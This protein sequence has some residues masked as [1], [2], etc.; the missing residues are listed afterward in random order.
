[1]NGSRK[2]GPSGGFASLLGAAAVV[3]LAAG[4]PRV[5]AAQEDFRNADLDRPLLTEDAVPVKLREWEVELGARGRLA[6]GGGTGA[7]AVAE[8]KTGLFLNTQVGVELEGAVDDGAE[9]TESGLESL[10]AHILYGFDRETWSWPAFALRGDVRSPGAGE[11][12]REDWG[13]RV[14]GIA[15]R[16]VGRLRLHA[17]AGYDVA[18]AADGDDAWIAGLAFDYP[19]GLFS[20]LVMADVFVEVPVD[21][22]RTRVW[23][24][25]G[26]RWQLSNLSVL[27]LGLATRLDEWEA[28]RANVE[29][30]VGLSRAF[31]I[32]AL[33]DVPPYPDPRID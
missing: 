5:A 31:G 11:A 10:G 21:R 23:L 29:L 32:P 28:G 8:V 33:V 12:G 30:V 16:S 18:S 1:M 7:D 3:T 9:G 2:L 14:K 20:R 25:T 6:E 4:S 17:N 22:G 24:E 27:D 15:T 26:T 13:A 19:I